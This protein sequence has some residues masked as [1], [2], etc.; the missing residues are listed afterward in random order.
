MT[1]QTQ[2]PA[3]TE[4]KSPI[5]AQLYKDNVQQRFQELLGERASAFM[6]SVMSV[7]KDNDQLSQAEPSSV[8]NAAMTAATLDMPIDNNLG[9]AY[10]VPYKDGKSGKT[11]AQF[12]LGYKGFIQLAQRSGQFK[13]ISATP[14][15]QGQIVTADPLRGY[16]FDFTQGHD[17]E[18]VGY[19]AYFALLNGFEKTLYMSKAEM[20]QHAASYAAGYKKGYSN[21]NRKFDEM[22]LKTVIKQL[23][24]KYAPLSVDMQKAQQSDQ[25]VAV[26]EPNAI[27]QQEQAPEIDASQ[28]KTQAND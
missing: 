11:Y 14:V 1:E 2:Q 22:A 7:V 15:R 23:L 25:T 24:S 6:T 26:E 20:E 13:T 10:I 21:W 17:K 8:L 4:S 5:K 28:T 27:E 3:K 16:E 18:V 19:A 9:M 12:Q